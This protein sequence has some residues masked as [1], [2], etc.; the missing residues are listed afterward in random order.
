MAVPPELQAQLRPFPSPAG[1]TV[2]AT[3]DPVHRFDLDAL[4]KVMENWNPHTQS[5]DALPVI[6][7]GSDGFRLQVSHG[8]RRADEME[9]FIDFALAVI[10]VI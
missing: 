9:S 4:A 7:I 2:Q 6:Q 1:L 8:M 10:R 5:S 3:V